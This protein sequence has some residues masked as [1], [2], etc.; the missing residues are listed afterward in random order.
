MGKYK[1]YMLINKL[2]DMQEQYI[3]ITYA[4]S[5]FVVLNLFA[6]FVMVVVFHW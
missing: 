5:K 6:L 3:Y 4:N 2:F 1:L